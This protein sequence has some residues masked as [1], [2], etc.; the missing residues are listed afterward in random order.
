VTPDPG[1]I[2]VNIHPAHNWDELVAITTTL[3]EEA[4]LT[5]L[6][7]EK[8]MIDGRHTGTGGGNHIVVGGPTAA[9]SPFLR[10]PDLLRSL[11]T[12]WQNH[13][14][15]SYLFSGLFL[16]PTSQAPRVDEARNDQLYELEIAFAQIPDPKD[17]ETIKPW[18]VD[19]ILRNLLIDVTGNTHRAEICIDKLYSPDGPTGRLGLVE[20]RAFEMPPHARMSIAQ[21]LVL[22]A[23]IAWF[24]REPW[25]KPLV[26]WGTMLHDRYMLPHF[27]WKDF[28]EVV[29]DLRRAGFAFEAEWFAP[30]LEFRFPVYGSVEHGGVT[31]ELRQALEP[32]HVMGEQGAAGATV[33]FV[34]SSVERLQ[35]R[36]VGLT[37]GR[38]VVGCNGRYI[39]LQPTGTRGES[40]AGIRFRA[41]QPP[42]CLH[43]TIGVDAPLI[44]DLFD[45]WSGRSLGG[46]TYHVVHPGGRS[47]D[48][49]PVNAFEAEARRITR[50]QPIGHTPGECEVPAATPSA[51]YPVTL[52]LRRHA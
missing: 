26:R 23:L 31:M 11:I 46:C 10:R 40:V 15:L 52:D 50:F 25:T 21:Q 24:W 9:D 2:E 49:F 34:D 22:R 5:R 39:P 32:W 33:R 6:G 47:F 7:T 38:H 36:V 17:G 16:G 51:E 14:S 1:V 8:F 4:R 35:M 28:L 30:H 27:V 19:R 20:F 29:D 42:T 18:L 41:W 44:F 37:E 43:P 3:Y 13:P 12:Y 45:T 48:T